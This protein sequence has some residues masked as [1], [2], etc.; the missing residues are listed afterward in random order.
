MPG[1]EQPDSTSYLRHMFG[2]ISG[3]YALMNRLIT[4]GFDRSW[5]RYV[6]RAAAPGQGA[7]LLDLGTG[8]GDIAFEALNSCSALKV[9]ALDFTFRM[10]E[11]GR[12]RPGGQR[13]SWC[14]ADALKLPFPDAI[15]D[16]VTSGYLV[17]NVVDVRHAFEEQ[18]RVV[19][20]GGRVVC[21]DTC[22]PRNNLI[23][24]F[25]LFHMKVL[26]PLLGHLVT[27]NR[28]AYTYLPT[29]TRAF[30]TPEHLAKVMRDVGFEDVFFRRFMFGTQAVHVG[31]RPA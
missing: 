4:F 3:R 22:P 9:V 23:R 15:F 6:V 14:S 29:S 19:K 28:A 5:R 31:V 8:P 25:V 13:I 30:M 1:P 24:P 12:R 18:M 17:R 2:Q 21:L 26:I 7:R 11:V 16:A 27:R 10:M 20:P